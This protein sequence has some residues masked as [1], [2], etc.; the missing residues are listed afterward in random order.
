MAHLIQAD[1]LSSAWLEAV[2]HLLAGDGKAVNLNV[3]FPGGR[4]N[5]RIRDR[6]SD[7]L[8][9]VGVSRRNPDVQPGSDFLG[10]RFGMGPAGTGF[11]EGTRIFQYADNQHS[12]AQKFEELT[13]VKLEAM[14]RRSSKFVTFGL[15][16]GLQFFVRAHRP[17]SF[18]AFAAL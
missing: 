12:P 1:D 7:F 14:G 4:E 11:L 2:S 9:D 16:E 17:A 10:K 3:A 18:M 8:A 15:N 6:L 5:E 13:P